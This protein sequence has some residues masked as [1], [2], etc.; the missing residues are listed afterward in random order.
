MYLEGKSFQQ[1][2]KILTDE[3]IVKGKPWRDT[4]ID[5][6]INNRIYMGDYEQYKRIS[7]K[8]NQEP[9]IYM[10]VIEPIISR[11]MWEECQRQKEINQRSY[12]RD[13]C[14]CSSKIKCP[15]CGR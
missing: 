15:I 10:N 13:V 1:I 14:M 2:A 11:A 8:I 9:V 3:E 12:T 6:I 5:K 4:T 7:K